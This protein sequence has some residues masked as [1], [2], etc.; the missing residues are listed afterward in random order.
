MSDS[1]DPDSSSPI[2]GIDDSTYQTLAFILPLIVFL[3]IGSFYPDFSNSTGTTGAASPEA[4][5]YLA[6]V[7]VQIVVA[8]GLLTWFHKIHLRHFPL[9]FSWLSVV[10]GV[11]GIVIWLVLCEI[12]LEK[13]FLALIGLEDWFPDRPSFNPF[14]EFSDNGFR[15]IF[16]GLRFTLLA[17][18]VPI[19]EEL[20]IRGWL[21][22]WIEDP[23][24]QPIRLTQ[25]SFKALAAASVYGVLT[26]PGEALAAIAWF[27]LVSW[28]MHRTGNL[29][30]CVIAHAVTNLLLGIYVIYANAWHLW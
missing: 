15:A 13:K 9:K 23:D 18:I 6:M 20:F 16:L 26:H 14:A 17:A 8:V 3:V 4:K 5:N 7:G 25:L 12:Q 22:R 28:L 24:W 27:G 2:A 11:V 30:D 19:V 10:V 29:W 1:F 21:V